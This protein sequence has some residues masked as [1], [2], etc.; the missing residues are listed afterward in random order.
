MHILEVR[1]S[2]HL[3]EKR[4]YSA[5]EMTLEKRLLQFSTD[6]QRKK[7]E[8]TELHAKIFVQQ[9]PLATVMAW[10][11]QEWRKLSKLSRNLL[12]AI[13]GVH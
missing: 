7:N 13:Y 3:S 11:T 5:T 1:V 10:R 6:N 4:K 12:T 9:N 8:Q 2:V